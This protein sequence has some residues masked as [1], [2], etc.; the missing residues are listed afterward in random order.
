[1]H[2]TQTCILNV[3]DYLLE[4]TN[5]GYFTG[6]VFLDLKKALDTVYHERLLDKLNNIGVR[7]L[8]LDWFSS[9]LHGRQQVTKIN[10]NYSF[11]G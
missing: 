4:N 7:G 6:A 2:S 8:E 5:S 9:D 10:D 1:M 3:S 11:L